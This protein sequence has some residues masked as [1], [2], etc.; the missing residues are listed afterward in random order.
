MVGVGCRVWGLG[1]GQAAASGGGD[2]FLAGRGRPEAD[3]HR[4]IGEEGVVSRQLEMAAGEG[5]HHLD[6]GRGGDALFE[7]GLAA[8]DF[9]EERFDFFEVVFHGDVG[10]GLGVRRRRSLGGG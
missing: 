5:V 9:G 7:H 2:G 8:E 1:C 10:W 6:R 3:Q 4:E